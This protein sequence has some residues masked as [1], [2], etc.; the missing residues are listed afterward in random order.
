MGNIDWIRPK[1]QQVL[2]ELVRKGGVVKRLGLTLNEATISKIA[3]AEKTWSHKHGL[4]DGT[5]FLYRKQV[6]QKGDE[7]WVD[8][9][10]WPHCMACPTIFNATTKRRHHCR[11]CG[12][13]VCATC[14]TKRADFLADGSKGNGITTM[15]GES[16]VEPSQKVICDV[17]SLVKTF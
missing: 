3:E 5:L 17:G 10:A 14:T 11:G 8:D 4:G 2:L 7:G 12:I 13:L 9:D 15:F 1:Q 6:V 16:G